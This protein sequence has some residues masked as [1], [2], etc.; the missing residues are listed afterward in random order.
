MEAHASRYRPSGEM[1]LNARTG[2]P[3]VNSMVY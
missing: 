3:G 1:L 2:D